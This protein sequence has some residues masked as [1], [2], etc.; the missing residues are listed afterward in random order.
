M[1]MTIIY[2]IAAI[3]GSAMSIIMFIAIVRIWQILNEII[4]SGAIPSVLE[5][6]AK[7]DAKEILKIEYIPDYKRLAAITHILSGLD[8]DKEAI[9]LLHKLNELRE[10]QA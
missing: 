2:W 9:E 5:A 7:R 10:R 6:R 3:I 8:K 4:A 1:A